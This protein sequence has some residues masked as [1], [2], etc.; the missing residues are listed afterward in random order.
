MTARALGDPNP[1]VGV[2]SLLQAPLASADAAMDGLQLA[3]DVIGIFDPTGLVDLVNAGM[4]AARGKPEDAF[5]TGLGVVPI[6]G[7]VAKVA[8]LPR[9]ALAPARKIDAHWGAGMYRHG[10]LTTTIEHIMYRH[11]WNSGF[12]NVS[13]FSPGT[14]AR[15]IVSYVEEALRYGDVLQKGDAYEV[16]YDFGEVI[17]VDVRGRPTSRIKVI[18]RARDKVIRTAYPF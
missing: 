1:Y 7:D 13:R 11:G 18:I 17:G 8:K 9:L 16:E 4:Y 3:L 6:V 2:H 15:D 12:A 10:G 5:L 14:S